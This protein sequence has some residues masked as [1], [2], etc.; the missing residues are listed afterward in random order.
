MP[1]PAVLAGRKRLP[2]GNRSRAGGRL[3]WCQ[4]QL[5]AGMAGRACAAGRQVGGAQLKSLRP[6]PTRPLHDHW[7][8]CVH[9]WGLL[10]GGPLRCRAG[11]LQQL[12]QAPHQVD[13]SAA[14]GCLHGEVK[15]GPPL[16]CR[17]RKEQ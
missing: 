1:S 4:P 5:E 9:C 3:T 16:L 12:Q 17:A 15:D 11:G 8:Q 7:H 10:R 13:G 14:G 2:H 6:L